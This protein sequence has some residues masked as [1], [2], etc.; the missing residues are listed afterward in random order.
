MAIGVKRWSCGGSNHDKNAGFSL[1]TILSFSHGLL[2]K[3]VR[4]AFRC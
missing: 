4:N 2:S 1:Q 3:F